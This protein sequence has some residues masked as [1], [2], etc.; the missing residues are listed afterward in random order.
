[1]KFGLFLNKEIAKT[2]HDLGMHLIKYIKFRGDFNYLV[3]I[4]FV[5]S[6]LKNL[7]L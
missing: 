1:M 4:L 2:P 3:G 7:C 5:Y 6:I